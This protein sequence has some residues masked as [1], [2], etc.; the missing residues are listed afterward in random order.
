VSITPAARPARFAFT[1]SYALF[2]NHAGVCVAT[3]AGIPA[4][5]LVVV[6]EERELRERFGAEYAEYCRRV[7][8]FLPPGAEPPGH[9]IG[10]LRHVG[11]CPGRETGRRKAGRAARRGDPARTEKATPA[12]GA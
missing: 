11:R 2:V 3:V 10:Q 4:L 8:G 12:R 7:P 9:S 5:S 6:L 1:T